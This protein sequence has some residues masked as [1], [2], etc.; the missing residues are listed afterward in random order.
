MDYIDSNV[1]L[2][3]LLLRFTAQDLRD[4]DRQFSHLTVREKQ[5]KVWVIFLAQKSRSIVKIS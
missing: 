3:G 4:S 5:H 2:I 1:A